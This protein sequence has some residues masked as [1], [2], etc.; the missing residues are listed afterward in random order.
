MEK[1]TNSTSERLGYPKGRRKTWNLYSK[2]QQALKLLRICGHEQRSTGFLWILFGPKVQSEITER[3]IQLLLPPLPAPAF[4]ENPP[5]ISQ[6]SENPINPINPKP[7]QN[8]QRVP[9]LPL[10]L[11]GN[12]R[13]PGDFGEEKREFPPSSGL[14]ESRA[15]DGFLPR[16]SRTLKVSACTESTRMA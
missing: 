13:I 3:E 8:S 12:E 5:G 16:T 7:L 10:F 2:L 4:Q 6:P 15:G 11:V 14:S 9:R 1:G